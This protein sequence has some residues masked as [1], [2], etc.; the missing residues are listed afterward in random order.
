MDK[1]KSQMLGQGEG[2]VFFQFPTVGIL[3]GLKSYIYFTT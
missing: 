1:E 2:V 3:R